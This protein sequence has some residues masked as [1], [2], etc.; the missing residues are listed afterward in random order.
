VLILLIG[1]I[2]RNTWP[3]LG[4]K[5]GKTGGHVR[6]NFRRD[7]GPCV[8][9]GSYRKV[10]RSKR[11][12]RDPNGGIGAGAKLE[13]E[14]G[15][16]GGGGGGRP[17]TKKRGSQKT[18]NDLGEKQPGNR[19]NCQGQRGGGLKK[20]IWKKPKDSDVSLAG[21][22]HGGFST[23]RFV[24]ANLKGR[25][26]FFSV[27]G[28]VYWAIARIYTQTRQGGLLGTEGY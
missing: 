1:H 13:R 11:R 14:N 22:L 10:R 21:R 27:R 8:A 15:D 4:E 28:E 24:A 19:K 9:R 20:R 18:K 25:V 16:F 26:I 12:D 3:A 23:P 6:G 2:G 7:C 5:T 17:R